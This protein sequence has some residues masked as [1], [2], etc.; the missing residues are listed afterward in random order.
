[1]GGAPRS[2]KTA[3]T[4][5]PIAPVLA[6]R[7]SPYA[8]DPRPL[9]AADLRSLFEAARWAPSSFNEQPWR[10]LVAV[11][12]DEGEF[13]RLLACLVEGNRV[14]A[15][16]A[17][18]LMVA[19][20]ALTLARDG[21]PNGKALHDLGLAAANLTVEATV[22]GL[23]VHQM[24]GILPD[25]VRREYG[26]PDDFQPV[27]ALAVGYPGDGSALPEALRAKDEAP[28]TRRPQAEFVF[29]GRW[30]QAAVLD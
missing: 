12:E 20:A 13:A 4:D 14:W 22:R 18:A 25:Q 19:V 21:R 3:R 29:A 8:F 28:R 2:N 10:Y 23:V 9:P 24:G 15:R 26:V 5:H 6:E 1:M 11:R 7:H 30:G 17:S 16:H 27:T